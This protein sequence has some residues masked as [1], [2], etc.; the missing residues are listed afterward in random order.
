MNLPLANAQPLS[1]LPPEKSALAEQLVQGLDAQALTWLSGYMAGAAMQLQSAP[2]AAAPAVNSAPDARLTVLYGSQTGN[3]KRVAE[4]L[5]QQAETAGL[6]VQLVRADAYRPRELKK[7]SLLYVV[8]STHSVGDTVEPPDDSRDFIEFLEGRRAPKLPDLRYAVLALGDSSY[9]DFCGIGRLVDER[10]EALGAQRLQQRG[11]AD[12]DI[13]SVA[14]PWTNTALENAVETLKTGDPAASSRTSGGVVTPLRPATP[15]GTRQRPFAAEIL[16]NQRIVA[17]DSIKDVRHIEL[18]LEDSGITYQPGD[19]L[20][21]WPRQAPELVAAVIDTL[22]LDGDQEIEH[23]G[24]HLRLGQ[25]LS[26]RREL[27]TLTRPFIEAHAERGGHDDLADLLKPEARARFTELLE[28]HQ[29]LDLLR[30]WPADWDGRALVAALRPLAPR[31]YSIASSQALVEDEVHLTVEHLR[32]S[33]Q[34]EDRWGV[35][36]RYLCDLAEGDSVSVFI[37]ANDRFRLP[38]DTSRDVIMIGPGT[39][40][41]PFRAFV[42][43]RR[44]AAAEGRQ[45]LFFGNPH[46]R[47]DFLY[48][49]EWQLARHEGALTN[50]SVAFSRDQADKIYVQDRLRENGRELWEWLEG[51]AHLYVCGDADRMAPDVRDALIEIAAE[52]G[53]KSDEEAADWLKQMMTDGRYARDVY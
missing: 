32:Y 50:L 22:G 4:Q 1:P 9:A 10:L 33:H 17:A 27:T 26:E 30:R 34:G 6:T 42:Q 12:V 47:S 45:W 23:D 19:A 18:S 49:L 37:E 11:E 14:E 25:W 31:M 16:A 13:D 43:E 21:V 40:V 5:A 3:A 51:G 35:A 7:E 8:V 29:L 52:H 20:G 28:T 36:T 38:A 24:E 2:D 53:G 48:Q 41:A 15:A 46:R 39:G 44:E